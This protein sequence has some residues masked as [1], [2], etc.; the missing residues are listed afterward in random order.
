MSIPKG[1]TSY[2]GRFDDPEK[3]RL[4]AQNGVRIRLDPGDLGYSS[5]WD[6][7]YSPNTGKIYFAPCHE[8]GIGSQTRL[9]SYDFDTDESKIELKLE[10]LTLPKER[11]MPHTKLHESIS[12]MPDGKL[13]ATTHS[14]DRAPQQPEWMPFAHVDHVW[15]GFPGS[16][17]IQFDPETGDAR[18]LGMPAPRESIYGGTYVASREAFYMIGFM[19]GHCYRYSFKDQSV[20]DLG[21]AAE[22][23]CY[24]MHEGP[25]HNVY[26]MT[27]SGF[28]FRIN[29]EIDELEDLNWRVPATDNYSNNTWYRYMNQGVNVSDHEFVFT[30]CQA[31]DF[32]LFDTNTLKVRS[33]GKRSPFDSGHG[34]QYTPLDLDE[35]GVDRDGVLWYSGNCHSHD[36]PTDEYYHTKNPCVL[37]RWDYRHGKSPEYLGIVGTPEA[38]TSCMMCITV[39]PIRNRLFGICNAVPTGETKQQLAVLAID[40]DEYQKHMNERGPVCEGLEAVPFTEEEIEKTK[41]KEAK[42]ASW[43]G[44]EVSEKNPF[45]AVP[46]PNVVPLR[47]W[48][49]VPYTEI[50]ESKVQGIAWDTDGTVHGI[51]GDKKKYYFHI[52]PRPTETFASKEEADANDDVKVWRSIL[53][54]RGNE[55]MEDGVYKVDV[56][57]SFSYK[58][59]EVKPY[60]ELC[61]CRKKWLDENMTPGKLE[62]LPE[63]I[64]LPEVS[65]RRYLAVGTATVKLADG[66]IA[67]GTKD[68]MFCLIK[69]GKVFNMGNAAP[70]GPVRCLCTAPDGLT[71][72]GTCGDDED[73]GTIFSYDDENGLTQV[74]LI[75]YNSHGWMDGPT[76]ANV[77]SSIAV[78]PDGKMLA[79]GGADRMGS[80][81]ILIL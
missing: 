20:K 12:F 48:R 18:N 25:D 53:K 21:K 23:F 37:V 52:V 16:Y 70:M 51:C 9:V 28:L 4:I 8:R 31:D 34:F 46:I 75:N 57:T 61:E 81:H 26:G 27:K 72:Y 36:L 3:L 73:M 7:N 77:L 10:K 62:E 40:L 67:V 17:I 65:G 59:A 60:D 76:S 79:V 43:A 38:Y 80:V 24:R 2:F 63:G 45:Q 6:L 1:K 41:A 49:G 15:E 39:D 68:G 50:P 55:R 74:G 19:R 58:I 13:L 64:K 78:S 44:E 42:G 22:V 11:Q 71:V 47:L 30:T 35:F 14:T 54:Q 29:T 56:P 32:F 66:R 69:N 33:L 5:C